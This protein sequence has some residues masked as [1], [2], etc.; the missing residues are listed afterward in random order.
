[1]KK[2]IKLREGDAIPE[3]AKYLHTEREPNQERVRYEWRQ[4]P[5]IMGAIPIFG[6]D[7]LYRITPVETV[8]Y[9]EVLS[10]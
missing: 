3:G 6:T 9:Y 10:R 1:M 4:T 2:I 8:H 5:G 7:T